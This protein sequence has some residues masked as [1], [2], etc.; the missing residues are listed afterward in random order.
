MGRRIKFGLFAG[1]LALALVAAAGAKLT[2]NN[3]ASDTLVFG[4]ASDPVVLDGPLVS[5]GESLR[6]IDQIFEGLVGLKPGSTQVVPLLA[7]SWTASKNG[8][9]WTFTLRKG[10]TFQ[11]RTPFNAAAVC[12]N[13]SRWY[14]FPGPLQDSSVTYY[15]NTVFG[16]FANPASGNP[17]PDKSLYRGCKAVGK[18]KVNIF[19]NRRSSS[20]IG[21]LALTNFGIASPTALQ[22][23]RA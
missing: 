22:K 4:A 20:F 1:A 3:K 17:G 8:L 16:G 7:T 10:V 6:V 14:N 12:F 21:A 15:W 2:S 19:L 13:F 18:Y 9:I 5:D 11:D 23:Y